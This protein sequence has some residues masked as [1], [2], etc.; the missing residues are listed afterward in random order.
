MKRQRVDVTELEFSI[1]THE[2]PDNAV[3]LYNNCFQLWK[4]LWNETFEELGEEKKVDAD[5]F[6][7]LNEL[8]ILHMGEIPIGLI[9]IK[10]IDLLLEPTLSTSYFKSFPEETLEKLKQNDLNKVGGIGNLVFSKQY[11]RSNSNIPWA[12]LLVGLCMKRVFEAGG[13]SSLCYTRNNRGVDKLAY[14]YGG[15]ALWKKLVRHNVEVD[16]ITM[17]K[18]NFKESDRPEVQEWTEILWENRNPH[19]FSLKVAA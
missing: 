1:L 3:K 19:E 7:V 4:T 11:R 14:T 17:Q 13:K 15:N 18:K 16:I 2:V 6:H 12:E 8:C 5:E 10:W 9:S